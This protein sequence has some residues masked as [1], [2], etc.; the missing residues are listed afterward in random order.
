MKNKNKYKEWKRPKP[1]KKLQWE[2]KGQI[3]LINDSLSWTWW[4]FCRSFPEML[5]TV[6]IGWIWGYVVEIIEMIN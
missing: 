3:K 6:S 4:I 5:S 2:N 1:F